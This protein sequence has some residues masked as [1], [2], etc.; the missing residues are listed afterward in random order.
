MEQ[1]PKETHRGSSVSESKVGGGSDSE[2]GLNERVTLNVG[3]RR[4]ETY[5]STL[6]QYP[7]TLLGA[8]FS[9]RNSHMRKP[10]RHGEFFFDRDPDAFRTVVNF[11]RTGRLFPTPGVSPELLADE[12]AYFQIKSMGGGGTG[13]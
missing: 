12:L 4:F 10:D 2:A 1:P 13:I 11:Y 9:P 8:M 3:G 6:A 5:A 7:D